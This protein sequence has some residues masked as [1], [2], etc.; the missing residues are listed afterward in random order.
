MFEC[1]YV[2]CKFLIKTTRMGWKLTKDLIYLSKSH[3]VS[4]ID[5]HYPPHPLTY[6]DWTFPIPTQPHHA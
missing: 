5:V 6:E 3:L 2:G 1:K 4:L